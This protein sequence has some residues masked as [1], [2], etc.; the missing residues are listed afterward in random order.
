MIRASLP[1]WLL[2]KC[3]GGLSCIC[4]FLG[5]EVDS[6]EDSDLYSDSTSSVKST[7]AAKAK[8]LLKLSF[9]CFV[10]VL[11]FGLLKP[12]RP[13]PPSLE[14]SADFLVICNILFGLVSHWVGSES[15]RK[16]RPG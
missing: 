15:C 7:T 6:G 1:E 14:C 13:K 16:F 12:A 8:V 4:D 11:Y 9:Y 5:M 10:L 2:N 3:S